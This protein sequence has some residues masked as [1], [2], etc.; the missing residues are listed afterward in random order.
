M[1]K[2]IYETLTDLQTETSVPI[3][4]DKDGVVLRE[5]FGMVKHSLP[6]DI[7]PTVEQFETPGML[8]EFFEEIDRTHEALQKAVQAMIIDLR[9]AFK[10]MPK[11]GEWT[12]AIGQAKVDESDWTFVKKP[13]SG[14]N[15]KIDQARYN[16]CLAMIATLTG[17][18]M[19][20]E[21]IVSIVTP[22]Y[23]DETVN[24]CFDALN[25]AE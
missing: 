25:S 1:A 17:Q 24:A 5:S 9:A 10:A 20:K 4:K 14:S 19:A 22:I 3:V 18:K 13:G 23:G 2:S 12:P 8:L 16:D 21:N 11:E 6:A 15:K 7:L